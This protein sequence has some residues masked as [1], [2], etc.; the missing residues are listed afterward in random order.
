MRSLPPEE[1]DVSVSFLWAWLGRV[2]FLQRTF[3][4]VIQDDIQQTILLIRNQRMVEQRCLPFFQLACQTDEEKCFDGL[5]PG[6]R[7]GTPESC[8]S[9]MVRTLKRGQVTRTALCDRPIQVQAFSFIH[10]HIL[11]IFGKFSLISSF[12]G[13]RAKFRLSLLRRRTRSLS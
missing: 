3:T 11:K 2:A 6:S 13:A 8:R 4:Q 7:G 10:F 1:T 9:G 12:A 5:T